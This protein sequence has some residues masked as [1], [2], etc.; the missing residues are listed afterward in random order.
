MAE[1]AETPRRKGRDPILMIGTIVLAVAFVVVISGYVYGQ[2]ASEAKEPAK[3]GNAVKV[4]YVGSYYG[5]YDE[6]GSQIFDTSMWSFAKYY[7]DEGSPYDFSWEFTQRAESAYV[8]FNVTIGSG[9]ALKDFENVLI[10]MKPGDKARIEIENAYGVVPAA[11]NKVWGKTMQF[12]V[13]ETMSVDTFKA[14]FGLDYVY[15]G[16]YADLEHPYGWKANAVCDSNGIV[17]VTHLVENKAYENTDGSLKATVT[18]LPAANFD[19]AFDFVDYEDK[20][21]QFKYD[22]QTYYVTEVTPTGF[23]TKSTDERTGMTLY[24]EIT[25]VDYQ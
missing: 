13:V 16:S 6:D 18:G 2:F 1:D 23:T 21:V 11:K 9:G 3:Y 5:W 7:D 12:D 24:F 4:N 22:G 10:G 14:T 15:V 17:T 8:P 20:L 25:F 19:V